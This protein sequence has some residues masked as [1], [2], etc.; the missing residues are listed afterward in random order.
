MQ[1]IIDGCMRVY[2]GET[3]LKFAATDSGEIEQIINQSCLEL[4]VSADDVQI[5]AKLWWQLGGVTH[6]I[7]GR[8]QRRRE[9]RPEFVAERG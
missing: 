4:N 9:R 8:C 7:T 1:R 3:E 6:E 2:S 5:I